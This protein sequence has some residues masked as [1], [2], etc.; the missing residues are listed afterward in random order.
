MNDKIL[1]RLNFHNPWWI[2]GSIPLALSPSFRR[3]IFAKLLKYLTLDRVIILKGPRRTGKSTIM[4]QL[5]SHLI[6]S[7]QVTPER[8]CYLSF[9]DPQLRLDLLD[10]LR[11]YEQFHAHSISGP[12]MTYLF[13]DEIH[14]LP[15]WSSLIK[16]LYDKKLPLKIFISD[17]SASILTHQ[18]ESLA[19]RTIEETI[20]PLSFPEW[21]SYQQK[22][23]PSSLNHPDSQL[24]AKYLKHSGFMHLLDVEDPSLRA[25]MLLEDVVTKAIYKDSVEIFGLREPA[26]LERLFGY[27][28][29]ASAG[30][31]NISKLSSMLGIDR[32][33]TSRYLSFLE[34]TYLIFP[35]Q[36]YSHLIRESIRSQNKIHLIDQGFGAIFATPPDSLF[37]SVV[38]RHVWEKYPGHTY[39]W[40]D[41]LEVDLVVKHHDTLIP[42]E[43]KNTISVSTKEL[44]G[45]ITF[46]TEYHARTGYVIYLGP[47][48]TIQKDGL[49]LNFLPAWEFLNHLEL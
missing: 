20:L 6:A 30:L 8:L 29:T 1:E 46:A 15:H 35:L 23:T 22:S 44:G 11:A 3:P 5:M 18:S 33:Q 42:I 38:A 39:F 9:D 4:Y 26:I 13:L 37:E 21:A 36:K 7:G 17:S 16:L 19:G 25:K 43:I 14:N 27:L 32:T 28:A 10:I 48:K 34:N 40:R 2:T 49:T 45:I 12:A 41:R 31:V 24:F 47:R